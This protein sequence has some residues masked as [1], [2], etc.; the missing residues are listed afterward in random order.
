MDLKR[1]LK[2][3]I[4][5]SSSEFISKALNFITYTILARKFLAE[6]FGQISLIFVI[7][8]YLTLIINFGTETI[9]SRDVARENT[10][11]TDYVSKVLTGKIILAFVLYVIYCVLVSII[12]IEHQFKIAFIIYG[13]TFFSNA[14]LINWFFIGLEKNYA[15]VTAQVSSSIFTLVTVYFMINNASGIVTAVSIFTVSSFVNSIILLIIFKRIGFILK[16]NLDRSFIKDLIRVCAPIGISTLLINVYANADHIMLGVMGYNMEL[17]YYAAAYK[18]IIIAVIP[19]A[20]ILKSFYPQLSKSVDNHD[21]RN[22]LMGNY[23]KL[24]FVSGTTLSFILIAFSENIIKIVYGIKFLH[25]VDLLHILGFNVFLV[26]IT[27]TYGNPLLAWNEHK[28]YLIA[29]TIGAGVNLIF[30]FI[31][32]PKYLATGAAYATI[33]SELS[34]FAGVIYFHWLKTKRIYLGDLS[35]SLLCGLAAISTAFIC[36]LV[37]FNFVV[38]FIIASVVLIGMFYLTRLIDNNILKLLVFK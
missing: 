23:T 14:V 28:K 21:E 20:I 2:N 12:P 4:Y 24:M 18:I 16:L 1:I 30:N 27:V 36:S 38:S 5:L 7:V 33:L 22:K 13:I 9:G 31:L 17:G 10:N 8:S 34:V 3:I 29:I 37:P 25:S 35:K 26:F 6:G 11:H 19:A 15:V 32:I